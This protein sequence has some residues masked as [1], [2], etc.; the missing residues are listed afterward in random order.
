MI[1]QCSMHICICW[2]LLIYII[3]K[4]AKKITQTKSF[5]K[6]MI[7]IITKKYIT[8]DNDNELRLFW[9]AK[10]QKVFAPQSQN[11]VST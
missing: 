7:N 9:H 5:D 10:L 1:L 6:I 8:Y 2:L 11:E 3:K 4:H